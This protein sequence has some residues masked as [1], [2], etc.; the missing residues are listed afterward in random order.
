MGP[1]I[2]F[3]GLSGSGKST[4]AK[5]AKELFEK[6]S[7]IYPQ[8]SNWEIID[9]DTVR[10]FLE[11]EIG[12]NFE[13][14]RKIVTIIGL[15]ANYLSK[16][17]IGVIVANISPFHDI[18]EKFRKEMPNYIE[19]YCQCSISTCITRDPK[20]HYRNQFKNGIKNFVGLD[21]PFQAP[22]NPHLI[23]NTELNTIDQC[24]SLFLKYIVNTG[25]GDL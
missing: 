24:M 6:N 22:E 18:R 11:S 5:N 7:D 3:I 21:I 4:L 1:I 23:L 25:G 14:R 16:Y 13:D 10:V 12:Y 15:L 20:S 9:G 19:V 8:V 2:W 17:N